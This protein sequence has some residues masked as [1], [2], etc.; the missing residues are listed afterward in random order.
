MTAAGSGGSPSDYAEQVLDEVRRSISPGDKVL[1]AA[2]ERRDTVKTAAMKFR[3]T[4]RSFNCGSLAH[5]TAN[6]PSTTPTAALCSTGALTTTSD[7]TAP[8]SVRW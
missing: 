1:K 7:P 2:R 6:D 5:G 8:V 3:G 4:A